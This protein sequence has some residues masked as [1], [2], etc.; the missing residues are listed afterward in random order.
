M[1][2]VRAHTFKEKL[3]KKELLELLLLINSSKVA[4][5]AKHIFVSSCS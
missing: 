3:E 5:T 1:V 2:T 4:H